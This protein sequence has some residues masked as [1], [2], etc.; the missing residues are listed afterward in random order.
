MHNSNRSGA[1]EMKAASLQMAW[2][3][4]TGS[5]TPTA[6]LVVRGG[7]VPRSRLRNGALGLTRS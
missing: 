3:V 2:L 7:L 5:H 1:K 4:M 6:R